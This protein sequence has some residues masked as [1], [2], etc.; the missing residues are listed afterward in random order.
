MEDA[1][2]QGVLTFFFCFCFFSLPTVSE[3]E[4]KKYLLLSGGLTKITG[5][6]FALLP[7][8]VTQPHLA[9]L[10][11]KAHSEVRAFSAKL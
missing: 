11:E 1:I 10:S 3:N 5:A 2:I 9:A 8:E 6:E 7:A 4:K